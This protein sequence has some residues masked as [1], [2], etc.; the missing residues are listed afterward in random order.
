[1]GILL[2]KNKVIDIIDIDP[3]EFTY[4]NLV[5][6]SSDNGLTVK[7][8][9]KATGTTVE[10]PRRQADKN[11][12]LVHPKFYYALVGLLVLNR[13]PNVRKVSKVKK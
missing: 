6:I 5:E 11:N 13:Q 1:M 7:E 9:T 12:G 10:T 4:S 3:N 8:V 2:N